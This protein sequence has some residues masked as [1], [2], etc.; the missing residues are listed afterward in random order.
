MSLLTWVP[1]AHHFISAIWMEDMRTIIANEEK[2][3]PRFLSISV[4]L[5]LWFL[6]GTCVLGYGKY[7][8]WVGPPGPV[9][10]SQLCPD[11]SIPQLAAAAGTV[12]CW[13]L[14]SSLFSQC[15]WG[16]WRWEQKECLRAA[17]HL[18]CDDFIPSDCTLILVHA[19]WA[20]GVGKHSPVLMPEI[21]LLWNCD[22]SWWR[23]TEGITGDSF[24]S[25]TMYPSPDQIPQHFRKSPLTICYLPGKVDTEPQ[26]YRVK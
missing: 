19:H 1:V 17:M 15:R 24:S 4:Y 13:G 10:L 26:Q 25:R 22:H 7:S 3:L 12:Q 2:M 18:I 11:A 9:Q 20:S 23:H 16:Q 14:L 21:H 5:C 8:S 6:T